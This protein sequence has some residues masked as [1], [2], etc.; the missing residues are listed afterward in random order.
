M[1]AVS[2]RVWCQ[3]RVS[4]RTASMM[5]LTPM[6]AASISSVGVPE[7]GSPRTARWTGCSGSPARGAEDRLAD[8]AF[9]VVVLD[10]DQPAFG[11]VCR[12]EECLAVDRLTP[13]RSMTRTR[14]PSW[15][16]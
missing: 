6:P 15:A 8:A 2:G 13:Y 10:D 4:L 14:R 11:H 7:A 3:Q 16:R 12:V 5:A 9:R 1:Y